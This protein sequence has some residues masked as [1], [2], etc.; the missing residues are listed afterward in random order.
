MERVWD[1]ASTPDF[2]RR[3]IMDACLAL[4]LRAAGVT[5]FATRNTVHFPGLG[6]ERVFD[7]LVTGTAA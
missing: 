5:E 4:T 3:R 1:V 7:P 6:F 2:A